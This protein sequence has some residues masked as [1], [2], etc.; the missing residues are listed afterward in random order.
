MNHNPHRAGLCEQST[1]ALDHRSITALPPIK[2]VLRQGTLFD[3]ALAALA[4]S[5]ILG[6]IA[7]FPLARCPAVPAARSCGALAYPRVPH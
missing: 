4:A 1:G 6:G 5:S 7:F 3:F 2:G